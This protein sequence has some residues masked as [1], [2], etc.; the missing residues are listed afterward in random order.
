MVNS[1]MKF[2]DQIGCKVIWSTVFKR[3]WFKPQPGYQLMWR[4]LMFFSVQVNADVLS[5]YSTR[6][7][8]ETFLLASQPKIYW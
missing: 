1:F 8:P 7:P 6:M 3:Y 4:F 5:S 2:S